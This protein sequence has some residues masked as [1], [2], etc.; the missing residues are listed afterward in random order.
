MRMDEHLAARRR[1]RRLDDGRANQKN[2]PNGRRQG[3]SVAGRDQSRREQHA[4]RSSRTSEGGG[5]LK[6]KL[7]DQDYDGR[8]CRVSRRGLDGC[9]MRTTWRRERLTPKSLQGAAKPEWTVLAAASDSWSIRCRSAWTRSALASPSQG[10]DK[11]DRGR[12]ADRELE[13]FLSRSHRAVQRR[14]GGD[15]VRRGR[16]A[17]ARVERLLQ[18]FG[19]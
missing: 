15:A 8:H 14:H 7:A 18:K 11:E 13:N 2:L 17:K 9:V 4:A 19:A 10:L 16:A 5:P 12:K 3:G 1:R 6:K